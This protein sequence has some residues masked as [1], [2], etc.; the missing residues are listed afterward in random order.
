MESDSSRVK[1]RRAVGND[2]EREIRLAAMVMG[3]AGEPAPSSSTEWMRARREPVCL[4]VTMTDW[5][6]VWDACMRG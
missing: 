6:S 4:P 2:W 3:D 1:P 5:R